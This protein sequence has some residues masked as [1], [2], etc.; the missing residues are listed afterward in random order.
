MSENKPERYGLRWSR[1]QKRTEEEEEEF[2]EETELLQPH[3]QPC[4][5]LYFFYKLW[6][7]ASRLCLAMLIILDIN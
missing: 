5:I 7:G 1:D 6:L 3:Y 4:H 2:R